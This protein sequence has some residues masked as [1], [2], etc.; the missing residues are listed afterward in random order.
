MVV[1]GKIATQG[2]TQAFCLC[3][4]HKWVYFQGVVVKDRVIFPSHSYYVAFILVKTYT[5]GL[6]PRFQFS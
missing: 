3:Y 2:H 4:R 1:P 5:P 6:F